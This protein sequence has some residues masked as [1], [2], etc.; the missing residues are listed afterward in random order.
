MIAVSFIIF[1]LIGFVIFNPFMVTRDKMN[2]QS[3]PSLLGFS[4]YCVVCVGLFYYLMFNG[5]NISWWRNFA[6]QETSRQNNF[7]GVQTEPVPVNNPVQEEYVVRNDIYWGALYDTT[8][9]VINSLSEYD[10]MNKSDIYSM[11]K[12][13]VDEVGKGLGGDYTPTESLLGAIQ[14][15]KPW[16]GTEGILCKGQGRHASDG[17]SRESSYFNNPFI[18]LNLGLGRVMNGNR[19]KEN[20]AGLWPQPY[21]LTVF[22]RAKT[23]RVEYDLS[24]FM[25]E[26]EGSAFYNSVNETDWFEF[27]SINARDFGYEYAKAYKTDGIRFA[28]ENNVSNGAR[29]RNYWCLGRSC[30]ISGGCNNICPSNDPFTFFVTKYPA[31]AL[32]K[33]YKNPTDYSG[34]PDAYFEIYLN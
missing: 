12:R 31:Y 17:A 19:G 26:F 16:W 29:L 10:G 30:Q 33:L 7:V 28:H 14:D 2:G 11:R 21:R 34:E 32:F 5:N 25:R 24:G 22:P 3:T 20:C 23:I 27:A 1:L 18:L 8:S 9:L 4:I 13:I 6:G 15:G